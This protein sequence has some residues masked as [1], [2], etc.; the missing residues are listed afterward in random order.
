[1]HWYA[2]DKCVDKTRIEN[3]AL[4]EFPR[5]LVRFLFLCDNFLGMA[6]SMGAG[7]S[8]LWQFVKGFRNSP[9]GD[10]WTGGFFNARNRAP[11]TA[12][13][14]AAWGACFAAFDCTF[15]ALRQ[16]EDMLNAVAAGTAT[17]FALSIRGGIRAAT[18]SAVIGGVMLALIE[19]AMMMVNNM[20]QQTPRSNFNMMKEQQAAHEKMRANALAKG[21]NPDEMTPAQ[22]YMEDMKGKL[23]FGGFGGMNSTSDS[24]AGATTTF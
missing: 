18:Q 23:P 5:I 10:K 22:L 1:M 17:G 8:F 4:I 21:L 2:V 12:G 20:A 6:F 3:P 16:K 24:S 15:I 14:F 19:G 11:I 13:N 7:G 9:K